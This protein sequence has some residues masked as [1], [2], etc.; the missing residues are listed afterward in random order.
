MHPRLLTPLVLFALAA[1]AAEPHQPALPPTV[2]QSGAVQ[3]EAGFDR[4]QGEALLAQ[5]KAAE[6]RNSGEAKSLYRQA[7]MAWP[8]LTDAWDGLKRVSAKQNDADE[9]KAAGFMAER[10]KL[11]PGT[12][13]ASQREVNVALHTYIQAQAQQPT[14]GPEQLA[15]A[16]RLGEF[17]DA[18]YA[19]AGFYTRE[20]NFGN[21]EGHDIPAVA[22]TGGGILG[23][24][25]SMATKLE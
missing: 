20:K 12:A 7:G 2:L 8:D 23:Y 17:Y 25:I 11:Y 24:G 18:Q 13:I 5:A 6:A 9:A 22:L 21:I 19:L 10:V 1:C 4:G 14:D 3:G 16:K 15:Y